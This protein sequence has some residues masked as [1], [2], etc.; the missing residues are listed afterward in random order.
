M[1]AT[2]KK[3]DSIIDRLP[4][5]GVSY[6]AAAHKLNRQTIYNILKGK[7]L[8]Y[9]EETMN[10][11]VISALE[12]IKSKSQSNLEFVKQKMTALGMN[13]NHKG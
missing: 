1:I 13:G 11:V 12:Y 8:G 10:R 4:K 2:K 6:L 3:E 7:D 5:G 9:S